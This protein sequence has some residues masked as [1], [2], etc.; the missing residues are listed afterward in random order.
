MFWVDRAFFFGILLSDNILHLREVVMF[1]D[2][3]TP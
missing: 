2:V 3:L 1:E